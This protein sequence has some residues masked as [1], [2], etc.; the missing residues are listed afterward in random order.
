MPRTAVSITRSGCL[1]SRILPAVVEL[2]R[3]GPAR[4]PVVG[5]L[6][7]LVAGELHLLG[8][9]D[10]HEV[11]GVGVGREERVVLAAQ[12]RWRRG[13]ARRPSTT[14]LASTTIQRSGTSP[15]LAL[16]VAPGGCPAIALGS[17]CSGPREARV[18]S[19][20]PPARQAHCRA[21]PSGLRGNQ[22]SDAQPGVRPRAG[23]VGPAQ[24]AVPRRQE[25]RRGSPAPAGRAPPRCSVPA[26]LRTMWRRKPSPSSSRAS[27]PPASPG[28]LGTEERAHRARSTPEPAAWKE[29][30]SRVPTR[31]AAAA[32][33]RGD[34]EALRHPVGEALAERRAHRGRSRSRSGRACGARR[35][36]GASPRA[37]RSTAT[38]REI[39]AAAPR[40]ARAGARR[41]RGGSRRARPPPARARA[42]PRR[43]VRRPPPRAA[44]A[45][46]PRER[47]GE[48][49]LHRA[50]ALR[51]A[52][53]AGEVR[54]VVL[55][56]RAASVGARSAALAHCAGRSGLRRCGR[57]CSRRGAPGRRRSRAAG[58]PAR[59]RVAAHAADEDAARGDGVA[60]GRAGGVR[61]PELDARRLQQQPR[62]RARGSRARG[63]RGRGSRRARRRSGRARA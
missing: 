31:C 6:L 36:A 13:V 30:K 11:A 54:P 63:S 47:L 21:N 59:A 45:A 43:C 3:A 37:P 1:P 55:E 25:R 16:R 8:V 2:S 44:R 15:G 20:G 4:V 17:P 48:H 24:A 32:R 58:P 35:G 28:E 10:D 27:S 46:D 41:A 53:P 9:H 40:S 7:A 33:H 29:R 39:V 42:R 56:H 51:L 61:V 14:S 34:V 23:A 5:L 60:R 57:R 26:T 50:L 12:P 22:Y 49:A 18:V 62:A 38:H 19:R 52:L